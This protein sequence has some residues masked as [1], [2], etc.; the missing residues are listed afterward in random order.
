LSMAT[1]FPKESLQI[2]RRNKGQCQYS[3][4]AH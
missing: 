2:G 4:I 1:A 3:N